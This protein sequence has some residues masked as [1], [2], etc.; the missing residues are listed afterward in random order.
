MG[1][2]YS[3]CWGEEK[4]IE[5]FGGRKPER[6]QLERIDFDGRWNKC[7]SPRNHL[8]LRAGLIWLRIITVSYCEHDNQI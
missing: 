3:I 5:H 7:G 2:V 8:G 6:R 4:C 1:G